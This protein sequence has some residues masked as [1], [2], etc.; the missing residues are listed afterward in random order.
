MEIQIAKSDLSAALQVATIG[1][2]SGSTSA[3]DLSSHYTFR[4]KDGSAEILTFNHRIYTGAPLTGAKVDGD[5][6]FTVEGARFQ[7]WV[8]ALGDDVITLSYDGKG[9]VEASTDWGSIRFASLDASKFPFWDADLK[10]AESRGKIDASR[11]QKTFSYLQPFILKGL[12]TTHPDKCLTEA[13]E[14]NFLATD[15]VAVTVV[16]MNDNGEPVLKEATLR[17]NGADVAKLVSFLGLGNG[18]VE[19]LE[20]EDKN[21]MFRLPN[22]SLFM[23]ARPRSAWPPIKVSPDDQDPMGWTVNTEELTRAIT[24]LRSGASKDKDNR[25]AQLL[26]FQWKDNQVHLSMAR[27]QGG[28]ENSLAID[29]TDTR[30]LDGLPDGGFRLPYSYLLQLMKLYKE[31]EFRFGITAKGTRGWCRFAKNDDGD[32]FVTMVSWQ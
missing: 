21:V 6:I 20:V 7:E 25:D 1:M 27:Y 19:V 5:G 2:G 17:V 16:Q 9:T 11:L 15:R 4:S 10:D 3:A 22:H 24:W 18:E 29:A 28:G 23:A 30:G 31:P 14:G 12:E 8:K 26:S 13:R 32:K